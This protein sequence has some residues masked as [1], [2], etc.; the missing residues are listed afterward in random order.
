MRHFG[1]KIAVPWPP[2]FLNRGERGCYVNLSFGDTIAVP[3]SPRFPN[4]VAII[5][6]LKR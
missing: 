1:D 2:R 3:L 5:E 4:R 6:H